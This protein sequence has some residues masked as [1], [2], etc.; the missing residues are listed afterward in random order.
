MK[1]FL[2]T[3]FLSVFSFSFSQVSY[4]DWDLSA[5]S[6]EAY[7]I[8]MKTGKYL[9][10]KVQENKNQLFYKLR[11]KEIF[12]QLDTTTHQQL[13]MALQKEYHLQTENV[14]FIHYID[15]LPVVSQMPAKDTLIQYQKKDSAGN[16]INA[17]RHLMSFET[18]KKNITKEIQKFKKWK[19]VTFV[20]LVNEVNDY[21][22]TIEDHRIMKDPMLL[23]RKVFSD[24]F[25]P[26]VNIILY[27]DG[28]FA[29]TARQMNESEIKRRLNKKKFEKEKK[30]WNP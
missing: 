5:I 21:P 29:M 7:R 16:I 10:V 14:L 27:P 4:Y 3:F 13:R 12:G 23:F 20:Q 19:Q 9:S 15:T 11:R 1:Y 24:G 2:L 30:N 18:E 8:K 26:Y 17:H 6:H 22:S 25:Q 28:S